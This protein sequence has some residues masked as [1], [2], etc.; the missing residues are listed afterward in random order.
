MIEEEN[1]LYLNTKTLKERGPLK[2]SKGKEK[3]IEVEDWLPKKIR[4]QT[5]INRGRIYENARIDLN[6]ATHNIN[7]LK[8]NNQKIE[9]LREWMT[10]NRLDIVGLA[11]TNISEREGRFLTQNIKNYK[12]FWSNADLNKKKG[13]GVGLLVN[14]QWEKH[15]GQIERTNEYMIMA[16]FMFKQLEIII[17]VV[18]LPPNDKE[19]RKVVQKAVID[20]Y[21]QR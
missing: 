12:S 3:A 11:E 2:K 15:L 10:D 5:K 1:T 16:T 17:M 14:Q 19:K 21:I 6:I 7:G 4:M 18:Y 9:T 13:S 8:T 20:K